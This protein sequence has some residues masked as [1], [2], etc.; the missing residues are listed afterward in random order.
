[1]AMINEMVIEIKALVNDTSISDVFIENVLK[2]L[3]TF[4]YVLL[5]SDIFL[6]AFSIQKVVSNI[7]NTCNINL[8]PEGLESIAI[9]RVCGEV[10]FSKKQTGQIDSTF[11]SEDLISSISIGGTSV[12]YAKA[13]SP[14]ERLNSLISYLI[15]K[16]E[17][18]FVSFRKLTW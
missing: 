11:L 3:E 13:Q 18:E 16:G 17:E 1:M 10:L 2:R 14:D 9:D 4:N 8:L 15:N 5:D 12:S 6:I 7:K